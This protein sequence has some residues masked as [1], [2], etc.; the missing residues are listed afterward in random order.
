[1]AKGSNPFRPAAY[2]KHLGGTPVEMPQKEPT[3]D[4]TKHQLV[5]KHTI[6]SEK[7]KKEVLEKYGVDE[8]QLP[9]ILNT[10]PVVVAIGAKP[11]QLLKIIRKSPTA[12]ESIVYRIVVENNE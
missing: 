8:T 7:E 6:L 3:F 5:P 4:I 12:K 2:R 10:D 1:M 11:G 9:K